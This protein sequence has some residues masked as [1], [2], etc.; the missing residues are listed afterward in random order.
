M[1]SSASPV[2]SP[3]EDLEMSLTRVRSCPSRSPPPLFHPGEEAYDALPPGSE[4]QFWLTKRRPKSSSLPRNRVAQKE[5]WR[6]GPRAQEKLTPRKTLRRRSCDPARVAACSAGW[7]K[8]VCLWE[9][10]P[11]S[12]RI[13]PHRRTS[14]PSLRSGR[15][16]YPPIGSGADADVGGPS[17]PPL[18]ATSRPRRRRRH[19]HSRPRRP[20]PGSHEA[21]ACSPRRTRRKRS[22]I[23]TSGG[24]RHLH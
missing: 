21:A 10:S 18:Q 2:P 9:V 13:K 5:G 4:V 3:A 14:S 20:Q 7:R 6:W 15:P 23:V 24:S 11:R 1:R 12:M 17:Q 8:S 22:I 16:L 19:P